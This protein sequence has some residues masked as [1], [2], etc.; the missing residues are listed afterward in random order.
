[1]RP[2]SQLDEIGAVATMIN[3]NQFKYGLEALQWRGLPGK[4]TTLF[5]E[6]VK[7]AGFKVSKKTP[8]NRTSGKCRRTG[9]P[10][11]RDRCD[12]QR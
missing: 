12:A 2:S 11:R 7:T 8:S 1:M 6:A 4:D 5:E 3:E 10:L 9:G